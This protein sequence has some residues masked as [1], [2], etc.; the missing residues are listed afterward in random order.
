MEITQRNAKL[1][2]ADLLLRWRNIPS[3]RKFSSHSRLIGIDEHLGWLTARLGRIQLEPF[4]VFEIDG[5]AIGM[6]RLD[7]M[8][9]SANKFEVSI[10]VDPDHQGKGVGK[11]VLNLVCK[12]FFDSHPDYAIFASVHK[13]N[14]VSQKLFAGAGF[15]LQPSTGDFLYFE[16]KSLH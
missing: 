1:D 5:E 7:E 2:D 14:I 6:S 8:I 15:D 12:T 16:K 9:G 3:T 11:K 10:S 13:H 4:F